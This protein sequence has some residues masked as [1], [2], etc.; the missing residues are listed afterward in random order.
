MISEILGTGR[1]NATTGAALAA[2][3]G[4][5]IREVTKE[6]ENERLAGVP[7]CATMGTPAGYFLPATIEDLRVYCKSLER[8]RD[9]IERVLQACKRESL[10]E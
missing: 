1:E 6:I 7:I 4:I 5:S 9:A 3:Y 2:F 10:L 8:R